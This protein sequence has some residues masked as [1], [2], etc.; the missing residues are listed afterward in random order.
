MIFL[1][2][3]F[4]IPNFPSRL[5]SY[6][7]AKIPVLAV[8]DCNTDIG[9]VIVNNNIGCWCESNNVDNFT[10]AL[11][12]ILQLENANF[13]KLAKEYSTKNS[14]EIIMNSVISRENRV[15]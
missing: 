14:Y 12:S 10:S 1:D 13:D 6:I 3:R 11:E 7:Q 4:T 5:L 2:Y 9:E 8:T 15:L